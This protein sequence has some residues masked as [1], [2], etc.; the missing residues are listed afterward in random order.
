VQEERFTLPSVYFGCKYLKDPITCLDAAIYKVIVAKKIECDDDR[1]RRIYKALFN[2]SMLNLKGNYEFTLI[3]LKKDDMLLLN[4]VKNEI[5]PNASFNFEHFQIKNICFK[6]IVNNPLLMGNVVRT[7]PIKPEKCTAKLDPTYEPDIKFICQ[8]VTIPMH[9]AVFGRVENLR[10]LLNDFG[11]SS[12]QP[13][14]MDKFSPDALKELQNFLYQGDVSQEC[15]ANIE[16]SLG[17][18]K[19]A[20]EWMIDDLK[21]IADT[22]IYQKIDSSNFLSVMTCAEDIQDKYLLELSQSW[23]DENT[24]N[25]NLEIDF[26]KITTFQLFQFQPLLSKY[27]LES[28]NGAVMDELRKKFELNS[29]FVEICNH[30]I[31]SKNVDKEKL[32]D[33]LLTKEFVEIL[34]KNK[35][36]YKDEWKAYKNYKL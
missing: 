35:E 20:K 9:K 30:V 2:M 19:L 8:G 33:N 10:N 18:S 32:L 4:T 7:A 11:H 1:Y 5:M 15:R 14:P 24:E 31:N 29:D 12:D 6:G 28:L 17:V 23:R 26:T 36:N 16:I 13:I 27:R 25:L 21:F 22:I 3:H 34:K